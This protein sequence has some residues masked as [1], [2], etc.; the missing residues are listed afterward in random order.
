MAAG[1]AF[2]KKYR[3]ALNDL[4]VFPIAD[5]DTGSN[6]YQTARQ[7]ALAALHRRT[8]S[9][10][11]AARA[12]AEGSLRGARGNSGTILSQLLRGFSEAVRDRD[13][14]ET[15]M[16]GHAMRKGVEAAKQAL[17]QPV[18]GTILTVAQA[19]ADAAERLAVRESDFFAL[20]DGMLKAAHESLL[21][22]PQQ[23]EALALADVVDAGGA[24][25]LYFLEGARR[26]G[27]STSYPLPER[28]MVNAAQRPA[29]GPNRY[30]TEFLLETSDK[31]AAQL[32]DRL[33]SLGD[34]LIV[35]GAEPLL[36]VHIHTD[37]PQRVAAA[38][39]EHG[40][41]KEI[42]VD[43]MAA[44][45]RQAL[46]THC[47]IAIVPGPGFARIFR[48]LGAGFAVSTDN[49]AWAAEFRNALAGC[50]G[51]KIVSVIVNDREAL[52]AVR[53]AVAER[54]DA[55]DVVASPHPPAG[56]AALLALPEGDVGSAMHRSRCVALT[57]AGKPDAAGG[58]SLSRAEAA[59]TGGEGRFA[60]DS[61]YEA[62]AAALNA[63]GAGAGGLITLYFG[64]AQNERNAETLSAQLRA[65]FPRAELRVLLRRSARSRVLDLLG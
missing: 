39:G 38:A 23:L 1:A 34:S 41:L 11:Q 51:A 47:V 48:E 9:L 22:T 16:L 49:D 20:C 30:C 14:I 29:I 58:T 53:E 61:L 46:R 35:A 6:L 32:R 37:L 59:G 62:A 60:G 65:A 10:A 21:K 18:E 13:A 25:F 57:F 2:L 63:L 43:D 33:A 26:F 19:S 36:R 7:A 24:G 3:G 50:S 17:T 45:V 12:A 42:K 56:I 28:H 64:G 15:P 44:P 8:G 55:I 5:A 54:A 27:G 52:A 4:N 40:A 31:R